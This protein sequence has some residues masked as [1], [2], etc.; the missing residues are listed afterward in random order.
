VSISSGA[1]SE[2]SLDNHHVNTRKPDGVVSFAE[3]KRNLSY[4]DDEHDESIHAY[5]KDEIIF[6]TF[7]VP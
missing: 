7:A 2:W 6:A 5:S 1:S 3:Y 4:S